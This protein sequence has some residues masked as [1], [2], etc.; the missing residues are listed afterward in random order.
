MAQV[1]FYAV[2]TL[3]KIH[4][5]LVNQICGALLM[6]LSNLSWS[7]L[8]DVQTHTGNSNITANSI[9]SEYRELF[10]VSEVAENELCH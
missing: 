7:T 1:Y 2:Q 6:T 10:V 8:L 4:F 3:S 9:T 5:L